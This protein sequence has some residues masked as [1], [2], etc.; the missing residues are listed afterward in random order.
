MGL[1]L[2]PNLPLA[3]IQLSS[4]EPMFIAATNPGDGSMGRFKTSTM[5]TEFESI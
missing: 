3:M 2:I 1:D 4:N 5:P